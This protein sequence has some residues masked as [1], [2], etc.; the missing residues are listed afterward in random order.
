MT[1]VLPALLPSRSSLE[2]GSAAVKKTLPVAMAVLRV[3]LA[4]IAAATQDLMATI[5]WLLRTLA[6]QPRLHSLL[7][8]MPSWNASYHRLPFL[9][10][11]TA[12]ARGWQSMRLALSIVT[13]PLRVGPPPN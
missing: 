5:R 8:C 9:L 13:T 6:C 10:F 3:L 2:A 11:G 4:A 1:P 7:A 12:A